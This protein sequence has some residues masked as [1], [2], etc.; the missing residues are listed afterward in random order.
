MGAFDT[1]EATALTR[2]VME[3]LKVR[4]AGSKIKAK[5]QA[6]GAT[7]GEVC[8]AIILAVEGTKIKGSKWTIVGNLG[9]V[10]VSTE[11]LKG[12]RGMV[13]KVDLSDM[14]KFPFPG[15]TDPRNGANRSEWVG[16]HSLATKMV[17]KDETIQ[18]KHAMSQQDYMVEGGFS[19]RAT[20]VPITMGEVLIW[21]AEAPGT[22][23]MIKDEADLR[24][25]GEYTA[26]IHTYGVKLVK[27][28][29]TTEAIGIMKQVEGDPVSKK[30][31]MY[32]LIQVS[33]R[34]P[35]KISDH[36]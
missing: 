16:V 11:R 30:W 7:G 12:E 29:K 23:E 17:T 8:A 15:A 4:G 36:S 13:V 10:D 22:P 5:L 31:G 14:T 20:V 24:G 6:C 27:T 34:N 26:N 28:S 35:K 3:K 33:H 18:D 25:L 9:Q 19:L 2:E 1:S 21:V 32:P